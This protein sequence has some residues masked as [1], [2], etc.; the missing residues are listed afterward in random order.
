MASSPLGELE[1]GLNFMKI[2]PIDIIK[3]MS[4]KVCQHSDTSI[5]LNHSSGIM[6][7]S[8]MCNPYTGPASAKQIAQQEAF[9]A[10]TALIS[11]WLLANRPSAENALGTD[12]YRR[13]LSLKKSLG[14]S[15]IRQV[16]SKYMDSKG[17]VTLP[18]VAKASGGASAGGGG[19]SGGGVVT[20][21]SGGGDDEDGGM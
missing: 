21:P 9:K 18:E 15:N 6:H 11:T 20:P 10:R 14:F 12:L 16:I 3:S 2:V 4:G 8:K 1:G 5:S 13:A 17:V 7:T 19:T